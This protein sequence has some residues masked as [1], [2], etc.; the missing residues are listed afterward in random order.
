M[1]Y[2]LKTTLYYY[3][4]IYVCN[5]RKFEKISL[6]NLIRNVTKVKNI[7]KEIAGNNEKRKMILYN[8]NWKKLKTS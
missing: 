1:I 4:K 8:K 5:S 6:N 3:S 7:D 2:Y